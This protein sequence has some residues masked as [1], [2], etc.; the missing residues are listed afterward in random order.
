MA[1]VA[2]R[3]RAVPRIQ[4]AKAGLRTER[5]MPLL[6]VVIILILGL[7]AKFADVFAPITRNYPWRMSTLRS[8]RLPCGQKAAGL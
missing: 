4:T 3:G 2:V 7:L 5:E 8:L 6:A 1:T